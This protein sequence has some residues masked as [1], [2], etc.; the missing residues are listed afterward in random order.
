MKRLLHPLLSLALTAS[1][2]AE[3]P[4]TKNQELKT[5][6]NGRPNVIVIITDDQG[7]GD[8]SAHG[9]PVL[10]TPNMDQFRECGALHRLS[11]RTDVLAHSR[12]THD[13]H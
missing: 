10:E 6:A 8:F 2:F 7:Y 5:S 13:R 11:C 4:R 3:K 12:A 1:V 9:N